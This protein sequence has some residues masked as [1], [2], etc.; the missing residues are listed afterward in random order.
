[1]LTD[2]HAKYYAH[3]LTKRCPS[4]SLEKL[5]S[6]LLDVRAKV[7][8]NPHQV[9][10]ALFAFHSPFSNGAILAD[11][12][13][14]GKTIE[15]GIIL[16]QKWAERK[17]KILIIVPSSLRKQWN[18]EL[19][20]KFFLPSLII[21]TR[22]FNQY[23]KNGCLNPMVQDQIIICSY[24]FARNKAEYIRMINWDMV[25]IDEAHRMRNVYKKSNI[26]AK[27]IKD[28]LRDSPKLL[29][30]ATPLQN[31]LLEL[32]GLVSFIDDYVFGDIKSFKN[33]FV[34]LS[35][36]TIFTD[37]KNRLAPLC[38]RTLRRQV[39]EYIKYTHRIPITQE[40]IPSEKEQILYDLVS[41]YLKRPNLQAL[42]ASQR[43]LMT[44][45]L[46]KLLA[47]STFAIA[48]ALD[49]LERKLA[50][51][52]KKHEKQENVE[53]YLAED[54]ESM[55]EEQDEWE[56]SEEEERLT[57][58]DLE[59][60]R[61]EIDDLHS[62]KELAISITENAKGEALIDSL[63]I[64]FNKAEEMGAAQKAVIFTE[65]RKTQNYLLRTLSESGYKDEIILFNGSNN[66]EKSK[67]VYREWFEKYKDT[68]MVT[69]SRTAD[70]RFALVNHFEDRARI[71]IATEAAAEGINLQFCSL[72]VNYDLPWNPQ[73]IEQRIGRCHR[74]G[75]KYDVVVVNFLNK[76]NAADQRVYEL[77]SEKFRLFEGVFGASDEVL[78]VIESG[79]DFEKR[80][81][82]IYQRCRTNEEIQSSFDSLQKE[83]ESH[84]DEKMKTTRN[85]I[86][87][88]FDEEVI[89]KLKINYRDTKEYINK[90]EQWLWELTR[91]YLEPY[92]Q[93]IPDD[94][95]FRLTKPILSDG[96]FPLRLYRLGGSNE[97]GNIYRLGHPLA[98]F[99]L[100]KAKET[101]LD[102]AEVIFNYSDT[103][104][105]ISIIEP[106]VGKSG[107][108]SLSLFTITALETEDHLIFAGMTDEGNHIDE[109]QAR[110]LFSLPGRVTDSIWSDIPERIKWATESRKTEILNQIAEKNS[111]FF[112][113]EMDKLE[114]WADDLKNS[115]DIQLRDMEKAIKFSKT[116]ARKIPVLSDK[117]KMQRR[118]KEMEKK[119]NELRKE[120]Y[121]SQDE[122]DERKESL[123]DRIEAELKQKIETKI[124]FGIR[125]VLQ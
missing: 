41:D 17:R 16:S 92:A 103:P 121:R 125:W 74:Y 104:G 117:L 107:F 108:L 120:L 62:F 76:N 99:L 6:S 124:L 110:R 42:P 77:L 109:E 112:D 40:F 31:S 32:F 28:A 8:L 87:E 30:T 91:Y 68:D 24:H 113:E 111:R 83:M 58:D 114:S 115:L 61:N 55:E 101:R 96:N 51:V 118:I 64:A 85:K 86:M 23:V 26:I 7:D 14:L 11:E 72:V 2:Y 57:Q 33:Q 94:M 4:D 90:Y 54:Y 45:I 71:M 82:Q 38:K 20:E 35:N 15:A 1:M 43:S 98:Q 13:G 106:L 75:Q 81:L 46:R 12:V 73:R 84:I 9:E 27:T 34:K 100:R 50:G 37:L 49:S 65:S 78:G 105:K 67:E 53:V 48:G 59:T 95:A 5:A 21:E 10:A 97:D 88:N 47:S 52:I 25:I 44:L 66:D 89:E 39:L 29:L 122:I 116:E 119:R 60:I 56:E 79:V 93:F 70:T 3:E 18:Q 19:Q 102:E 123:I 69:G 22:S 80:I 63:Q 36:E